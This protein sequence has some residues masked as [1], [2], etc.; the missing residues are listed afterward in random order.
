MARTQIG[1]HLQHDAPLEGFVLFCLDI[2][3]GTLNYFAIVWYT[4]GCMYL[5]QDL[6]F[7]FLLLFHSIGF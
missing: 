2:V 5:F 1:T 6:G 7:F 3:W 4:T